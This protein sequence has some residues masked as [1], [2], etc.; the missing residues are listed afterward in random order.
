VFCGF[1]VL[2][3]R[4]PVRW[5]HLAGFACIVAAAVFIFKKW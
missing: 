1:S 3:L 5:N 4:E 2:Y